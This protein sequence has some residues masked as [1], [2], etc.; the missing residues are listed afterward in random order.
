MK[1]NKSANNLSL[2]ELTSTFYYLFFHSYGYSWKNL[3]H[4]VHTAVEY[5][6]SGQSSPLSLHKTIYRSAYET[7]RTLKTLKIQIGLNRLLFLNI[8]ITETFNSPQELAR[9]FRMTF[10]QN[11]HSNFTEK[12]FL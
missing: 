8:Q 10:I 7:D 6:I 2:E 3:P 1:L 4:P 12:Y 9:P 5:Y 11:W